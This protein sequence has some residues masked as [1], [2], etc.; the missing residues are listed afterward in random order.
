[1]APVRGEGV[2][3]PLA[4]D[5][6]VDISWREGVHWGAIVVTGDAV[7][8]VE[9][10]GHPGVVGVV[11]VVGHFGFV[12]QPDGTFDDIA[13]EYDERGVGGELLD[14]GVHAFFQC[15]GRIAVVVAILS[16]RVVRHTWVIRGS[17][18][19]AADGFGAIVAGKMVSYCP[20]VSG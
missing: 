20:L 14:S 5:G 3:S 2:V 19:T 1:M 16:C 6:G 8:K 18:G 13:C 12:D 9:V 15:E 10:V 11:Q 4:G 17:I 7:D